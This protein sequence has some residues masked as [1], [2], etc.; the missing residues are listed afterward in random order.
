MEVLPYRK[1]DSILMIYII[2]NQKHIF[3]KSL[4]IKRKDVCVCLSTHQLSMV[5]LRANPMAY[6][7]SAGSPRHQGVIYLLYN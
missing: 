1:T 3:L 6:F 4:Y 7:E 5:D 2:N